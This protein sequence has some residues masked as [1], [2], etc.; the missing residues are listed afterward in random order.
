MSNKIDDNR[1]SVDSK[2]PI[3]INT[4]PDY[5]EENTFRAAEKR[6]RKLAYDKD[7]SKDKFKNITVWITWE[8]G[9]RL[10]QFIA[11]CK[12][13]VCF[14]CLKK[15]A[16]DNF[17]SNT[18]DELVLLCHRCNS[19]SIDGYKESKEWV[20][21]FNDILKDYG[22]SFMDGFPKIIMTKNKSNLSD[23][24]LMKSWTYDNLTDQQ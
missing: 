11:Y 20:H 6:D 9:Q 13:F 22:M 10:D 17:Y 24:T 8:Q 3:H 15:V 12:K 4:K 16:I 1:Y 14:H 18:Q 21:W 7:K 2:K 23:E 5:S 19:I